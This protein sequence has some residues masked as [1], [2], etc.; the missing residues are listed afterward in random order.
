MRGF[1]MSAA[2]AVGLA[3]PAVAAPLADN[4]TSFW[5]LGDSL[6]DDGN[7]SWAA[8]SL[9]GGPSSAVPGTNAYYN[10]A[11]GWFSAD[12]RFSN[13]PVWAEYVAQAFRDA[14]MATRN[15]AYG[16]ANAL[17]DGIPDA[18]D[19][20]PEIQWQRDQLRGQ[21]GGFGAA[22]L[23]SVMAG[24][25]DIFGA[26]S[27]GNLLAIAANA[28]REVATVARSLVG[29]GV[30]DFVM[31]RLPDIGA[32]PRYTLFDSANQANATAASAAY[33]AQI[34]IEI[35]A[36][37][38]DGLAVTSVDLWAIMADMMGRPALYGLSDVTRPCYF[39]S[40]SAASAAGQPERMCSPAQSAE[41][42]FFDEVHP[43]F[44]A[45][46]AVG[47]A[48]LAALTADPAPVPL[49]AG[50]PLMLVVVAGFALIGRRAGRA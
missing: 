4:Y 2:V 40:A 32:T 31:W 50:A 43:N 23:V 12:G 11:T 30:R 24:A 19:P 20:T 45:H 3:G 9:G 15:F 48:V 36:M 21:S 8:W 47:T 16:G 34:D 5:V 26:V 13:G 14:G 1:L 41:R 17:P 28:A 37:R 27:D 44:V 29:D 6:S 18:V 10:T 22:P 38:A 39:P 42:L 49:P 35:A 46:Q 7:L 33:N 25:N